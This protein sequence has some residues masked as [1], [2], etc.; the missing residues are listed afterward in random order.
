M[1]S[2]QL[3][4]CPDCG[5]LY[6]LSEVVSS[7]SLSPLSQTKQKV[8]EVQAVVESDIILVKWRR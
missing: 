1:E 5:C 8:D 6:L 4:T 3:L 2:Q 7:L